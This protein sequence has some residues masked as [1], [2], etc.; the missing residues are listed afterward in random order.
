[1][2][3]KTFSQTRQGQSSNNALALSP[4]FDWDGMREPM[5]F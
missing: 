3:G 2:G 1:M 4:S 5:I